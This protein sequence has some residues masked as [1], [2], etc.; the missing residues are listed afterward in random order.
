MPTTLGTDGP[1]VSGVV[2]VPVV[3]VVVVVVV[4]PSDTFRPATEPGAAFVLC[5]GSCERTSPFG[6]VEATRETRTRKPSAV[7]LAVATA[8]VR[9]TTRGT[10]TGRPLPFDS[11]SRMTEPFAARVSAAGL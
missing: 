4:G 6:L 2:E 10:A 11:V 8:S 5:A 7:S 1:R 9:P 3:V